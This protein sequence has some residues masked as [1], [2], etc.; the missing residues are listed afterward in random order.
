MISNK[1]SILIV[2]DVADNLTVLSEL[3]IAEGYLV[4]PVTSGAMALKTISNAIPDLILLDIKMPEMDG[5]QVCR[6][7]KADDK[8]KE[9]P[10]IF[11]SAYGEEAEKIK[12]FEAGGVDYIIKPFHSGEVYARVKTHL[13]LS[14][15]KR[16]LEQS[17]D[18]L[19][20]KIFQR[21][22]ELEESNHQL[23]NAEEKFHKAFHLN[24]IMMIISSLSSG[25][26]IEVNKAFENH[27]GY[28]RDEII[29]MA[30]KKN[31]LLPNIKTWDEI[32]SV[33]SAKGSYHNF[34]AEFFTKT[35]EKRIGHLSAD[36]VEV[37]TEPCILTVA[38]DITE[39]QQSEEKIQEQLNELQRWYNVTLNRENRLIEL[40][41]EVNA[42]LA[43]LNE[44]PRYSE[45]QKE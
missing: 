27:T 42:L 11:I 15:A 3:L 26:I 32:F 38:E 6:R 9:I 1:K 39:R 20:K 24:P 25:R 21:T 29:G 44:P 34:N 14:D 33:L 13:A 12:A 2:D 37:G 30:D 8:L 4:R 40:K 5:F 31:S 22:K 19:E 23:K 36:I 10:I 41:K 7:I 18:D 17:N 43:R 28:T 45:F 35:G 16:S